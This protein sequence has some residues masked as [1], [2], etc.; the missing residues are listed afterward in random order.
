MNIVDPVLVVESLSVTFPGSEKPA[1]TDVSFTVNK[2]EKIALLGLN[3][4]GKTSLLLAIAG[5][6]DFKG[7]IQVDGIQSN[8]KTITELRKK[9]GLLFANPEDQ[10]L[11]PNVLEDVT[12]TL[13]TH[14][15]DKASATETARTLLSELELTAIS[16]MS[17]H[18]LSDGQKHR[19]AL[20]GTIIHQPPL[21]LLDE[22]TSSLDTPG[23]KDL[24]KILQPLNSAMLLATHDLYFAKK[25]CSGYL[26]LDKGKL[27]HTG[28]DW[29]AIEKYYQW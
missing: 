28:H 14:G 19:V 7:T 27:A 8:K 6:L 9:L 25:V 1:I 2:G 17:P 15:V 5:L 16:D 11:I 26:F 18:Q 24:H 12:Y 10:L 23:K 29:E 22:P 20:A 13:L 3:A 4:S 21:L